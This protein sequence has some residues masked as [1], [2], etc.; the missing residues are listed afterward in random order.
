MNPIPQNQ[1]DEEK[2]VMPNITNPNSIHISGKLK[3]DGYRKIELH[4]YVD[5][6]ASLCIASKYVIPEEHWVNT[7]R[8]I[9]V[10]IADGNTISLNKVCKNL[11]IQIA[12]EL[13]HI[14][15]IYQQ[16]S[17]IDLIFG[18]N[19]L[20]LYGPFT[21]FTK[22]IIL[23]LTGEEVYIKK[24]TTARKVGIPGFLESIKKNSKKPKTDTI[25]ISPNK[26]QLLERGKD[27]IKKFK[28]LNFICYN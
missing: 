9:Q 20:Q 25:N 18:N 4:C 6:G 12:G 15:T 3:F 16:E 19:F 5:T 17:G 23:T 28:E 26:I 7:E 27:S 14:P 8:A 24:I 13:F 1:T 22:M 2:L 11:D 21:Q 10:K